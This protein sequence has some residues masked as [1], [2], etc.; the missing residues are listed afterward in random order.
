MAILCPQALNKAGLWTQGSGGKVTLV[1]W[2]SPPVSLRSQDKTQSRWKEGQGLSDLR[3]RS[4][5]PSR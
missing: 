2:G 5:C 1:S 4:L 3:P